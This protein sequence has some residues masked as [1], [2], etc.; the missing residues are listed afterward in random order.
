[1]PKLPQKNVSKCEQ[2]ENNLLDF[3]K[4]YTTPRSFLTKKYIVKNSISIKNKRYSKE[5][6]NKKI[7]NLNF[8]SYKWLPK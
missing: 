1:M 4:R 2:A 3:W 7:I 6:F 5:N 8:S